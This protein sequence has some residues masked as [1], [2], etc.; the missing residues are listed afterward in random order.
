MDKKTLD[1]DFKLRLNSADRNRVTSTTDVFNQALVYE[2]ERTPTVN[3]K[4]L[5]L[6]GSLYATYNYDNAER[7]QNI[8]NAAD[9]ATIGFT[10]FNDNAVQTR[11]YPNGVSTNYLYDNMRRLKRLTDTGPSGTLFD[12]QYAYNSANQISQIT[13][14]SQTRI[15]G[16]DN[17]NRLTGVTGSVTESYLFD[18]VGNR[19]SSHRAS[20]YGYQTGQFNRLTSA[21]TPSQTL[22]YGFDANGN[23]TSKSEGKEFWRYTWDYENRMSEVATRKQKVRYKYDALG[24]RVARNLGGGRELTKFTYEGQDVLVDDNFGTQTKYLNGSGIDTK[25]RA[26]A[27]STANY[28]LA[29]H[30][31]STNGL[32]N[33]SGS[34][35]A[36]T[37]YDSF[38]NPTSLTFPS[39]YQFTGREFDSFTGLQFSRARW[40]D[41]N[42]GRFISEDPIGF[43]GGDV[44]LYGYVKSNSINRTDPMGLLDTG[45]ADAEAA[46]RAAEAARLAKLSAAAGAGAGGGILSSVAA[47]GGVSVGAAGAATVGAVAVGGLAAGAGIGYYPGQAL[48]SWPGNPLINGPLNPFGPPFPMLPPWTPTTVSG[49]KC[50]VRPRPIP[51]TRDRISPW[52][53]DPDSDRGC[54]QQYANDQ[55]VCEGIPDPSMKAACYHHAF[56]RWASCKAGRNIPYNP[57]PSYP[58]E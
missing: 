19:E 12:R 8:V 51:W 4:R 3:Q 27:G 47:A 44:N 35:T 5:K 14:P 10:Y 6:N 33:S 26:T 55:A 23:T 13:E 11:T 16:Y 17:V 40:N 48:A 54:D 20:S 56:D 32:T 36:S 57:W 34:L 21:V 22:T 9:G 18:N 30:L 2:Y 29:D 53:N 7:L 45:Y 43:S 38:G 58:W 41:P 15:F 39:R 1:L 24:R 25:L 28:F 49:P 50:E 52:P 37:S 31:G 46:R 42:L